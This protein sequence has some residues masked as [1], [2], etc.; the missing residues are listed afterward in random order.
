MINILPYTATSACYFCL[1][2]GLAG[3]IKPN[4]VATRVGLQAINSMGVMEVRCMFGGLFIGLA[5]TCLVTENPFC[6]L[7]FSSV[8]L[9]GSAA[10]Y[11]SI[12]IDRPPVKAALLSASFDLFIGLAL[13]SGYYFQ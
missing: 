6:Y 4:I 11:L 7:A 2:A 1:F 3:L 12:L 10:K 5:A 8:W 9:G 13:V